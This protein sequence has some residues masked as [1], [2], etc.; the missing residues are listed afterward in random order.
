MSQQTLYVATRPCNHAVFVTDSRDTVV[1]AAGPDDA[2]E[3]GAEVK[4]WHGSGWR[5][6]TKAW[7]WVGRNQARFS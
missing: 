7:W 2:G 5:T 3:Q 4:R 1:L 6:R